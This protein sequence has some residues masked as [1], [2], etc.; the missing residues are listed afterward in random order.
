MALCAATLYLNGVG[1]TLTVYSQDLHGRRIRV[2]YSMTQKPHDPTPGQ[3]KPVFR[4]FVLVC[5]D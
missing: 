4:Y 5:A 2:D 3:C 1:Y